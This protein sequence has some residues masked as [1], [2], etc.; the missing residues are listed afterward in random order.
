MIS[1]I[2]NQPVRRWFWSVILLFMM[3]SSILILCIPL[4]ANAWIF[5]EDSQL[6]PAKQVQP[7]SVSTAS[8]MEES[9]QDFLQAYNNRNLQEIDNTLNNLLAVRKKSGFANATSYSL[10]LLALAQ[11]S[12]DRNDDTGAKTL[13]DKASSL[14]PD[15]S[16]PYQAKSQLYFARKQWFSSLH[17]CFAGIKKL[18]SNYLE[19]LQLFA[20]ICFVLAFLPLWLFI[21][22]HIVLNLKYFWALRESWE[23][24]LDKKSAMAILFLLLFSANALIYRPSMLL[25]GL[26][27]LFICFFPYYSFREK[28]CSFVL[29]LLL[30]ISPF[31]Y[32]NGIKIIDSIETPFFQSVMSINFNN[33]KDGDQQNVIQPQPSEAGQRLQLFSRAVIAGKEK[34][35]AAAISFLKELIR[36]DPHPPAAI[37]NNLGNYYY[38]DDQIEIAIS[39]YKKAIGINPSS[40]IYHYNLSHAYIKDSFSLTE[41]EASFIQA[42]KLSP[43]IVNRQLAKGQ[44]ANAPVL[45]HEPLPWSYIYHFVINHSLTLKL[46]TDFF[47]QYFSPWGETA[48]Y[49]TFIGIIVLIMSILWIKMDPSGRFCPLCGIRFHGIGR[50]S[51]VCPSCLYVSHQTVNDSFATRQQKRIRNFS[52]LMDGFFLLVGFVV[53]GT[54]QLA[55]GQTVRGILMLC[56]SFTIAGSIILLHE[57]IISIG[58]FPPG[59]AWGPLIIPLLLLIVSYLAN[60]YSWRQRK[61]Q[62]LI[63][64]MQD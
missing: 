23:R 63:L 11:H 1:N 40:G 25:P 64:R 62:R 37:Y 5:A 10:A 36:Q 39:T 3:G 61:Q 26:M 50:I 7:C 58:L 56:G 19:K 22:I 44:N 27:L 43:E 60:Y 17:S 49:L 52:W 38:M 45:I 20:G 32:L 2:A 46:K 18:F 9:W 12:H 53:P 57:R 21:S 6:E 28:I 16:F 4:P 14:S 41:S 29:I 30:V 33:Y 8:M 31:A 24:Q 59:A 13:V 55:L 15:Y 47:R 54:Y 35:T 42:W 48:S 34:R 51:D